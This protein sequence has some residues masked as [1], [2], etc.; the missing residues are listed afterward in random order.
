MSVLFFLIFLTVTW[1]R[2]Y[3]RRERDDTRTTLWEIFETT[4][5][6]RKKLYLVGT[7]NFVGV[8]KMCPNIINHP[9][10]TVY[11]YNYMKCANSKRVDRVPIRPLDFRINIIYS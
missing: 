4:S 2:K 6:I 5:K 11:S 8:S 1:E 7:L 10:R 3:S 9:T